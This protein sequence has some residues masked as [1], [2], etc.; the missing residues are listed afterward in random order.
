MNER[1]I[2]AIHQHFLSMK[3][4]TKIIIC[5]IWLHWFF[6]DPRQ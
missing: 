5:G 4:V 3:T 2:S 6:F 1:I